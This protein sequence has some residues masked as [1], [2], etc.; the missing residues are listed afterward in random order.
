VFAIGTS[1]VTCSATGTDDTPST[2]TVSFT[3]TVEGAAAQLA[4][5]SQA[6]QG[7]GPGTSLA[8][9]VALARSDLAAGDIAST[10]NTLSGFIQEVKAQADKMIP[11]ATASMLITDAQRIQ[12]VLGC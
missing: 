11:A 4:D 12:T 5:L 2:V 10:C 9:K 6:V 1:T 7:V 8:D 3:V